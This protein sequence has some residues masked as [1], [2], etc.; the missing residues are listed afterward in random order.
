MKR[1][2]LVIPLFILALAFSMTASV[3][4]SR[5]DGII[6]L[7]NFTKINWTFLNHYPFG[8]SEGQGVVVNGK[9]YVFGG[10][11]NYTFNPT[12]KVNMFDPVSQKWSAKKDMPT[13]LTH[14][15]FATDGQNIYYAGGYI[16]KTSGGVVI[17]G[18]IFGTK[19][20]W[21]YNVASD[22]YTAFPPLPVERAAGMLAIVNNELHYIGGTNIAR[23]VDVDTH[24]VLS[25]ADVDA[26]GNLL[27]G[28][29]GWQTKKP[30][31]N[32]RHHAAV[33]VVDGYIYYIG[34]QQKHDG[35]LIPLALVHRY[36]PATDTWEQMASMPDARNHMGFSTILIN[37]RFFV[38]GGQKENGYGKKNVYAYDI[39]N[40]TWTDLIDAKL[41]LDRHSGVA[42]FLNGYI[43]YSQGNSSE[44]YIGVPELDSRTATP[45]NT[46]TNTPSNTPTNTA[47]ATPSNTPSNTPTHTPTDTPTHTPT[48]TPTLDPNLTRELVENGGF[49]DVSTTTAKLPD[50]WVPVN[51]SGDRIR[52]AN[53]NLASA[54]TDSRSGACA[55]MFR[56]K[57]GKSLARINQKFKVSGADSGDTLTLIANFKAKNVQG[58]AKVVA[59][60]WFTDGSEPLVL[61]LKS[62]PGT[63]DYEQLVAQHVLTNSVT[64]IKVSVKYKGNAGKLFVDD[65][66]L[67]HT[68]AGSNVII[69]LPQGASDTR[70]N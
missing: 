57:L 55:F 52:C 53:A 67:L 58:R 4:P 69:P 12:R 70:S 19:A 46:P 13:G 61:R 17:P 10:F 32:P 18:Q 8:N 26:N 42:A 33:H 51:L 16:E 38:I 39:D 44:T 11:Y 60:I 24:Y 59:K 37:R 36:N 15:G 63:Y 6:N 68:E 54:F 62:K 43:V 31:P 7:D 29:P 14:G 3:E 45:T 23:T 66:S 22:T 28:K 41:P 65:V 25:L 30:L 49:E 27:P 1:A 21:R 40:N 5:A 35:E 20:V 34:G 50:I 47:T 9:L 2:L 56:G 48:H 64:R